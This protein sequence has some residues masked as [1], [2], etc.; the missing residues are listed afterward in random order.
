MATIE[1][2]DVAVIVGTDPT[3]EDIAFPYWRGT[4]EAFWQ[5]NQNQL[6]F[7]YIQT[8]KV[9][10]AEGGRIR[11]TRGPREFVLVSDILRLGSLLGTPY[12][13]ISG[14]PWFERQF[15]QELALQS[16]KYMA[17]VH[18]R[19]EGIRKAQTA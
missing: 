18:A 14:M 2:I 17:R 9:E 3:L 5:A 10:I 4:L 7:G 6:N 19:V 13:M 12:D 8:I 11:L 15:L 16:P 1:E